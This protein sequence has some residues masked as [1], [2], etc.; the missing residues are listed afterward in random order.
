M[1]SKLPVI[2]EL[3]SAICFLLGLHI[4]LVR[5][6]L[7]EIHASLTTYLGIIGINEPKFVTNKIKFYLFHANLVSESMNF[8]DGI[9]QNYLHPK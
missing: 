2:L 4:I 8:E 7:F 5:T 1:R 3:N 9:D 6:K